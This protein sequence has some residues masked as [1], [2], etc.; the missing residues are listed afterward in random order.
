[1]KKILFA[2]IA[3]FLLALQ[4]HADTDWPQV[5]EEVSIAPEK[6][7][8]TP[9][10]GGA[11]NVNYHLTHDGSHYF[12]R[13]APKV[14]ESLYADLS[15][16]YE[17]LDVASK[18]GVSTKPF[19]YD[20]EKRVLVTDFI[21]HDQENID[22][23]DPT[24]RQK[25]FELLHAIENSGVKI[26]RTFHPYHDV[27]KLL[28]TAKSLDCDTFS[29]E[30]YKVLMPSLEHIDAVLSRNPKKSLCHLDLHNKNV[31]K[32]RDRF[33]IVDWEYAAMSH[34]F[35]VLAS[36]ASIERWNDQQ[37]HTLLN[38]YMDFPSKEDFYRLYLYRIVADL[39][40]T[41]W[42]HV[43]E[44]CSPIDN[45]YADWEKLFY[46]AAVERVHSQQFQDA[47]AYLTANEKAR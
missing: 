46:E 11:S 7:Q 3:S 32:D 37:M 13:F 25:V 17:V 4:I 10:V 5:I 43:Q 24:T 18:L 44:H 29:Q 2:S 28:E 26:S 33:W 21:F 16:E 12:V 15:V 27:M 42:N 19:Y 34:P 22:L 39:F 36:M 38:D 9:V 14:V 47:M 40:W 35:L 30:F 31:V 41:A 20:P 8:L 6:Y 45:P 1:M 23:L